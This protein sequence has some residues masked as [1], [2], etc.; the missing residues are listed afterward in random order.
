MRLLLLLISL[1]MTSTHLYAMKNITPTLEKVSL[2]LKWKYQFQFAGFIMAKEKG[3]YRDVGLAVDLKEYQQGIDIINDVLSN[4]STYGVSDSGLI[5]EKIKGKPI[6]A[7]MAILQESANVLIGL[8]SSGIQKLEDLHGKNLALYKNANAMTVLSMLKSHHID[9]KLNNV[10]FDLDKLIS[11]EIDMSI[12]YISNEPF[13]AHEKG[14]DTIIFDPKDYGFDSYGDMLFTSQDRLKNHPRQVRNFYE[15]SKRGWIYAFGHIDEAV[16]IIY[17]KYNTLNKSKKALRYEANALKK[18]ADI[19]NNFGN[20]DKNKIK[21]IAL[22]LSFMINGKYNLSYLDDFIYKVAKEKIYLTKEEKEYLDNID[23]IDT[24]YL[25]TL[26]PYTM[27]KNGKPVG[28]TVDFLRV[29]EKRIGK[30][31]HFIYADT[32]KEQIT[33]VYNK[34]C[35]VVPLIQ[36]SPQ[37]LPFIK[38]TLS[39]GKDN[40][41]LVTRMDEPYIFNINTLKDKKIGIN[42]D[43]VHLTA[44]LDT[45]HPEIHYIKVEGNGLKEVEEGKLFGAIGTSIMMN[46]DLTR[47]YKDSLKI[48]TDYPDSYIEGSIGVRTDEPILFS[49]LNKAVASIETVK[50]EDIFA[51]WIDE[52]YKKVIDY[53]LIWKILSIS[54]IIILVTLFWNRRLKKEIK[55]REVIEKNLQET[56][57]SHIDF[58]ADLPIGVVSSDLTGKEDSYCNETFSQMFGW[59]FEDIDTVDKWFDKAYPDKQYRAKVIKEWGEKVEEAERNNKPYSTPMEVYITCKDGSIKWCQVNYYEKKGFLHAGLFVDISE[60]KK[61][62]HQIFELNNSLEKKIKNEIEKNEKHQLMMMEQTKLAQM[63]EM[64]EN[65]AHQWR[66]PLAQVNSAV[67]IIDITL[68]RNRFVNGLVNTKLLEIEDLTQHMSSTIDN[69]QDFFHPDKEKTTFYLRETVEKSIEIIQGTLSSNFTQVDVDVKASL[70]IRGYPSEL[71]Q[72]LVIILSNA[73]DVLRTREIQSPKIVIRLEESIDRYILSISD[74]AA[75]VDADKLD[76]VFEPYYTTKHKS[77]GRGLG[78]YMAKMLIEEGMEGKLTLK[79][80][81]DGACFSI[82]ILKEENDE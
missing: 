10:E 46:Y 22:L 79:N 68:K 44:Y 54:L 47:K 61:V 30:K 58:I 39:G 34:K 20:L 33:M 72:V 29:V 15:A 3:F 65:I 59:N 25:T 66:Q 50:Q 35:S 55:K 14:L 24:C 62:E 76:Q 64:I 74:N 80:K 4:K 57:D 13:V 32:I 17:S 6:V 41:V 38:P 70:E 81:A 67:L 9:Y 40:L 5:L 52:K 45:N 78:L 23:S 11:K 43:Y 51:E 82:E 2:Q 19:E 77:Q 49:I 75:G 16:D 48:M 1:S 26:E 31:F 18:L 7:M 60:L 73:N 21:S 36:T 27:L 37:A 71:Q 8:K 42:R 28:V 63:G 69:F 12:A 53:S 56:T